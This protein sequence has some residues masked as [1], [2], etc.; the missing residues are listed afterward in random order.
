MSIHKEKADQPTVT[1]TIPEIEKMHY[2][3]ITSGRAVLIN[4]TIN[5]IET[6]LNKITNLT[7]SEIVEN[8]FRSR[9]KSQVEE[10]IKGI[11]ILKKEINKTDEFPQAKPVNIKQNTLLTK[12][13]PTK[14]VLNIFLIISLIMITT[15]LAFNKL[16]TEMLGMTTA[17]VVAFVFLNLEKIKWFRGAG[18]EVEMQEA[19]TRAYAAIEDLKNLGLALTEP[20]VDTLTISG[21]LMQFI[22]LK[23]KLES[24]EK[25]RGTLQRLQASEGEIFQVTKTIY[26]FIE[27]RNIKIILN[28]LKSAN[29][30]KSELFN[31]YDNWNFNEWNYDRIKKL[32]SDNSLVV[33]EEINE[34]ITDLEYFMKTKKLRREENWQS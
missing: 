11:D 12:V 33:D 3:L 30:N 21:N 1:L 29:P 27:M 10:V 31:N 5:D 14:F 2:Q 28:L 13:D 8:E 32:I 7:Q 16:P 6:R 26:D 25:I 15:I 18:L 4:Q 20:I 9:I 22:H 24:V 17:F 19:V 23:N 34:W